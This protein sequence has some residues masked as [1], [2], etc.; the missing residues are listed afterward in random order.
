M[1]TC[2]HACLEIELLKDPQ[3]EDHSIVINGFISY[4]LVSLEI[5]QMYMYNLIQLC[6]ITVQH[7]KKVLHKFQAVLFNKLIKAKGEEKGNLQ[8]K[9]QVQYHVKMS[10]QRHNQMQMNTC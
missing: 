3:F 5:N 8:E 2:G 6:L 7:I 10:V 9:L 4:V 1:W